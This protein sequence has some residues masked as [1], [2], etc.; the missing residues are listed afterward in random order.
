M[1]LSNLLTKVIM[2]GVLI[3]SV[4]FIT[5]STFAGGAGP[6]A[7]YKVGGSIKDIEVFKKQKR[8]L[9]PDVTL[10]PGYKVVMEQLSQLYSYAPNIGVQLTNSLTSKNWYFAEFPKDDG[11]DDKKNAKS[12][13]NKKID[14]QEDVTIKAER[15]G[16]QDDHNIYLSHEYDI[17]NPCE[18]S[19]SYEEEKKIQLQGQLIYHEM[20]VAIARKQWNWNHN[21]PGHPNQNDV[22]NIVG[23]LLSQDQ[24]YHLALNPQQSLA[25]LLSEFNFDLYLGRSGPKNIPAIIKYLKSQ[26]ISAQAI[27]KPGVGI[28]ISY[29]STNK[30]LIPFQVEKN[31]IMYNLNSVDYAKFF[32]NDYSP[33]WTMCGYTYIQTTPTENKEN[34]SELTTSI[35]ITCEPNGHI[36]F[37]MDASGNLII[38]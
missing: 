21:N 18:S 23:A 6:D 29:Q 33:L 24:K 10:L 5:N 7:G 16:R 30:Q 35:K 9:I 31:E 34:P 15:I 14:L 2:R 19:C 8:G 26:D 3:S 11:G 38:P 25:T 27:Y 28:E 36:P 20:W 1:K 22:E 4:L 13:K 37:D 17:K 32:G 12:T